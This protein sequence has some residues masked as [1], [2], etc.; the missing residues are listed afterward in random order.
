MPALLQSTTPL[1]NFLKRPL[2]NTVLAI[3]YSY[4]GIVKWW[5]NFDFFLK[6]K[7]KMLLSFRQ[8]N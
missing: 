3:T 7:I 8:K 5:G 1:Q 4:T 2:G 6:S